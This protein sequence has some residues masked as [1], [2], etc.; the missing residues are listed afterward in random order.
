MLFQIITMGV[1]F[2]VLAPGSA[3]NIPEQAKIEKSRPAMA[4]ERLIRKY[5]LKLRLEPGVKYE[6][7]RLLYSC[8]LEKSL[9][10]RLRT[11]EKAFVIDV[12]KKR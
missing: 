6:Q 1:L 9:F 2:P 3:G 5:L 7:R 10:I 11:G 4:E 8:L 12:R